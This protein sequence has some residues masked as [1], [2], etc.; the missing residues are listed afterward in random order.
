MTENALLNNRH[1]EKCYSYKIISHKRKFI[2]FEYPKAGSSSIKTILLPLLLAE[3]NPKKYASYRLKR[4][5]KLL[6]GKETAI[7]PF[8]GLGDTEWL[9]IIPQAHFVDDLK[10][11][12]YKEYFKFSVVRNPFD[13][14]V[15]AYKHG[16][17]GVVDW[18]KESFEDFII[19][20]L[21]GNK[22]EL[23]D[24]FD[25]G[26]NHFVPWTTL[27]DI[28]DVDFIVRFENYNRDLS[29]A[30]KEIGIKAK[31]PEENVSRRN[32]K[33]RDFYT[34]KTRKIVEALYRKDLETF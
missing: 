30:L 15:S 29:K 5:I 4:T 7:W 8:G 31:I 27:F 19:S 32:K 2:F 25:R 34:Y 12:E 18:R 3:Y 22:R 33:Y 11:S 6:M 9:K 23:L 10:K 20:L 24:L 28:D 26:K 1:N 17:W 21:P 14:M 13:K 16:A